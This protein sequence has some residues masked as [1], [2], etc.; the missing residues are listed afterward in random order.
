MQGEQITMFF[1]RPAKLHLEIGDRVKVP[2]T[3]DGE[4]A[5][6]WDD[7][8]VGTVVSLS[9]DDDHR[10]CQVLV[11]GWD[12]PERYPEG[13]LR[14]TG[15]TLSV[16]EIEKVLAKVARLIDLEARSDYWHS[17]PYDGWDPGAEKQIRNGFT[18]MMWAPDDPERSS[19]ESR[20]AKLGHLEATTKVMRDRKLRTPAQGLAEV[21]ALLADG[22]PRTLNRIGLELWD[23]TADIVDRKIWHAMVDAVIAGQLEHSML[24]PIL[25]RLRRPAGSMAERIVAYLE[26]WLVDLEIERGVLPAR[27][28]PAER[29]LWAAQ[30]GRPWAIFLIDNDAHE[31]CRARGYLAE[32]QDG[33]SRWRLT[34]AG[35]QLAREP[36]NEGMAA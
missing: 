12:E 20:L 32:T 30:A 6:H 9:G 17:G 34:E 26:W 28:G 11:D 13:C 18:H 27:R 10:A 2:E 15:E 16:T 36:H 21:L 22:R 31:E 14:A 24:A 8:T 1:E 7:A 35:E 29:H 23:Q 3:P 19:R 33:V 25:I 5:T 4:P